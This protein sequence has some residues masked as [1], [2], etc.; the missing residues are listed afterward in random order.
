MDG[1]RFVIK[2]HIQLGIISIRFHREDLPL[3]NGLI[4]ILF[5]LKVDGAT[6][7]LILFQ[8]VRTALDLK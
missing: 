4:D 8:L 1:K 7:T 5:G 6:A 2:V 3:F